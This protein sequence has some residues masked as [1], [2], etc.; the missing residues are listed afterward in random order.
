MK[1]MILGVSLFAILCVLITGFLI[2]AKMNPVQNPTLLP[3][4][5]GEEKNPPSTGNRPMNEKTLDLYGLY[6]ENDLLV[7]R[8]SEKVDFCNDE[9]EIPVIKGLKN[10]EVESKI[11]ADIKQQVLE[12]LQA[13]SK[14]EKLQTIS[15]YIDVAG[16]FANVLSIRCNYMYQGEKET[17]SNDYSVFLNYEL[18]KGERLK[19]EDLFK[20]DADIYS[21]ARRAFFRAVAKEEVLGYEFMDEDIYYDAEK[22]AWMISYYEYNEETE[23][24][25]KV[26]KEYVLGVNEYDV[27]KMLN[28][29]MKEQ[30][31]SFYFSPSRFYIVY[32]GNYYSYCIDFKDIASEVVIYNRY[33]TENSLF[34][35]SDIGF[36]NLW[37]CSNS[38]TEYMEHFEYGFAE[39]NL[40]YEIISQKNGMASEHLFK[41]SY[42]KLGDEKIKRAK[43]K[44]EE[45]KKIAKENPDKF[46]VL[47][48]TYPFTDISSDT[49]LLSCS[50]HE[51]VLFA[52]LDHKN[53]IMNKI[54]EGYRYHNIGF[55]NGSG[56][57][58]GVYG[59]QL[60]TTLE[61]EEK[62]KMYD[63][64]NLTEITSLDKIF[65]SSVDYK[66]I[67]KSEIKKKR[68]NITEAE[69]N[70][71]IENLEYEIMGSGIGISL[72]RDYIFISFENLDKSTLKIGDIDTY[73]LPA[74]GVRKIEKS[75]IQSWSVDQLNKAYNEIFARYGHDF[76]NAE[77]K[78]YFSG[79]SWYDPI[80]NK[81][82]GIE[83]LNE[84]EQYNV[85]VIKS[86]IEEK[87]AE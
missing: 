56:V 10:K 12:Q 78:A 14:E 54:L 49:T 57:Y 58:Y 24:E 83:E 45:Y 36:K 11:N 19:F 67:I 68:E 27:S 35:T 61:D 20:K 5:S 3:A 1:K 76:K 28:K 71:I 30:D 86:V 38:N 31:Q 41:D 85:K 44:I 17:T 9:V 53:E 32:E 55:Y 40:Y 69:L 37:T 72:P 22:N 15:S 7:D 65:K 21:L 34:E 62:T 39:E 4:P 79:L 13:L 50:I 63:A 43:N 18:V 51:Y 74:S 16:N 59:D 47:S 52:S 8:V 81:A 26:T 64:R 77:L 87:K 2:E 66:E 6:N 29:F 80:L 42:E 70:R 23:K 82:V 84:F 75:E 46:Y 73:L 33:I 48:V 25:E 60:M